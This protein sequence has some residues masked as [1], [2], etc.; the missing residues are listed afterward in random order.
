MRE[1]QEHQHHADHRQDSKVLFGI[2]EDLREAMFDYQ[3]LSRPWYFFPMLTDMVDCLPNDNPRR[4]IQT[5]SERPS[6][7]SKQTR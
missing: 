7:V 6:F 5:D 4:R 3:V 1:D 2:L